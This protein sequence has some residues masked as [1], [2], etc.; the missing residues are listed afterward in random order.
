MA[1]S[2][3]TTYVLDRPNPL[4]GVEVSG[5]VL[6]PKYNSFVGLYPMPIRHGLTIGELCNLINTEYHLNARVQIV[7]MK[8]WRRQY[9]H[10]NT[11]LKWTIPS[12]N[13]PSFG[14]AFVYPGMCL[15]EGTN[16]SEGRG[17]TKPFE[18]FGA[19]WIDPF[20]LTLRIKKQRITGADFRPTYFIPTFNKFK[21]K[22]CGGA[23]IYVTDFKKFDAITTGLTIIKTIKNLY[24]KEFTWQKPPYEFEKRKMPF[25]IL[26]GNSWIRKAIENN[27]TIKSIKKKWQKDLQKFKRIRKNYLLY[28]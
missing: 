18:I 4:N 16:I 6:D 3:K 13:M 22:L 5:P 2:G 28:A 14:T 26:I 15:L 10:V 19:P 23:Q 25:D 21:G 11:G 8:G 7:K 27:R 12:P 17:T 20:R 24:P 9:Y 1:R